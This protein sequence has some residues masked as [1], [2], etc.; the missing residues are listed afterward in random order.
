MIDR[1]RLRIFCTLLIG[2]FVSGVLFVGYVCPDRLCSLYSG[3]PTSTPRLDAHHSNEQLKPTSLVSKDVIKRYKF[4]IDGDRDVMVFLHMQKTGGTTFGKHL[5]KNVALKRECECQEGRKRCDCLNNKDHYWLFSRYSTGWS[6]GLHADW[7]E[8][9]SCV[10]ESLNE[11]EDGV[12]DRKYYYI[13][14]LREPVQRYISEWKHT[15]RGSTWMSAELK[16]D[17]RQA[18]LSEVPFCFSGE[19]WTDVS[20]EEFTSCSSN[21]AHNRQTRMLANLSL[22]NCY[23]TKTMS[24]STRNKLLLQSAKENLSNMEFFGLTEFQRDTQFLFEETFNL[25]FIEDFQQSNMT[26]ANQ[27][28]LSQKELDAVTAKNKLDIELYEFAKTLFKSRVQQMR[29]VVN[30]RYTNADIDMTK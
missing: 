1:R 12:R 9:K 7:T 29:T 26:H 2:F 6:C 14:I 20:L 10:T 24:E 25:R 18:T 3:Y 4:D 27:A 15:Q 22:V 17:G 16:C 30:E 21:L 8:L 11:K 19:D 13:T 28:D 23:H 5:V